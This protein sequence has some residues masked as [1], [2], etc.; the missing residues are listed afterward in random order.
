MYCRF[1]FYLIEL[2]N[3]AIYRFIHHLNQLKQIQQTFVKSLVTLPENPS[4]ETFRL[5][6]SMTE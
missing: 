4:L 5:P 3:M 6:T 1:I 2:K